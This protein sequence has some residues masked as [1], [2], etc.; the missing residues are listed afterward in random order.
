[1][2]VFYNP[3]CVNRKIKCVFTCK[4]CQ[5]LHGMPQNEYGDLYV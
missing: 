5:F 3:P 1:M 4:D 2:Q